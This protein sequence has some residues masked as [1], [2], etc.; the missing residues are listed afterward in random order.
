MSTFSILIIEDDPAIGQSLLDGFDQ[1]GFNAHL[2]TTGSESIIYLEKHS[3]HL[4]ILDVR[5]PDGPGFDYC[6]KIR[7]RG[8][9]QPIIIL[10]AQHDQLD[11][12]LGLEIGADDYMTKPFHMRELISRVRAQIRRA[13]GD[14]AQNET[15]SLLIHDLIIDQISGQVQKDE[16]PLNLTPTEF[17]MLTYL[18]INKGRVLT[19]SQIVEAVWGISSDMDSEKTVTVHIRRLREK[20]EDNP[21]TPKI[22]LTVPGI[23]YRISNQVTNL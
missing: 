2:C 15:N 1:Y 3:P 18:C 17:R 14:Y 12:I 16:K 22:L 4:I 8:F 11:K 9:T 10:T 20:I 5:L 7:T 19:R 21:S 13:Y 23:G 6:R